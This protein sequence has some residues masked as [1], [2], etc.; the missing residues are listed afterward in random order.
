MNASHGVGF[1]ADRP[2]R[3]ISRMTRR[4]LAEGNPSVVAGKEA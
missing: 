4:P 3:V 2:C 1:A